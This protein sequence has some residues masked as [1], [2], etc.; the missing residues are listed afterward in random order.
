MGCL[1]L[2]LDENGG[3]RKQKDGGGRRNVGNPSSDLGKRR[4]YSNVWLCIH[5][6]NHPPLL[7]VG[8]RRGVR[9]SKKN[10]Q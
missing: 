1:G 10:G 7:V 8:R 2:N 5:A 4:K 3:R 6:K 9:E